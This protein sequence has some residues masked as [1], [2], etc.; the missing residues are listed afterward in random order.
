MEGDEK[1]NE[2]K[3][4]E[5][6]FLLGSPTFTELGGGRLRCL[7]TG[8]ELPAREKESYSRS[9]ACRLALIDASVAKK[10]PPLNMFRPD[11]LSKSKLVCELTGDSINK[12]EEHIWKHISG[13]RFQNKLEQKEAE[14]LASP[15]RVEKDVKQSKKLKKSSKTTAKKKEKDS[16]KNG[17]LDRKPNADNS[18]SEEPDFWVP[19]VGS[20]WDFDDGRDRW[21][22]CANSKEETDDGTEQDPKR[23]DPESME[24]SMQTKRMSIA[25]G[26][27][28]FAPRKKKSKKSSETLSKVN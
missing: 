13:R 10:K 8:H 24:L 15:K 3:E 17:S 20:R 14:K 4:K 22:S 5:G 11:P 27:S 28:S 18:D 1:K 2:K 25:V 16:D 26:P 7:E 6:S 19:P 21:E 9:K 12:T 23:D